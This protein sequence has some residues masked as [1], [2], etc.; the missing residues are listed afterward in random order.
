MLIKSAETIHGKPAK[1]NL[2]RPK[3]ETPKPI[4]DQ[5]MKFWYWY[6]TRRDKHSEVTFMNYGFSNHQELDLNEKDEFNRYPIQLYHYIACHLVIEG[7]DVLEVGS[8]RG[9]GAEYISRAFKP[10]SY[11]GV[12]LNKNAV[13]FCNNHYS[14][15][16]LSFTTANALNLP[17]KKNSFDVV[18]NVESSHRYANVDKFFSE[19]HRVLKPRGHFLFTDFRDNYLVDRLHHRLCNSKMDIKKKEFITPYIVKALDLDNN[20]REILINRL[21]PMV[22]RPIARDFAGLKGARMYRWFK[23]GRLEY[24]YYVMQKPY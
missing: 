24:L 7:L 14:R 23:T 9:G 2:R 13:K 22:F 1:S 19:V 5:F 10:K 16:G 17:F 3:I 4:V 6:I 11:K 18:I 12:D 21:S 20:R 8:G 15:S